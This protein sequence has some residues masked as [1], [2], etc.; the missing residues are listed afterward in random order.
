MSMW[1]G[2][3]L[4]RSRFCGWI[5]SG[6]TY[7][8]AWY[9]GTCNH[10]CL[11][12]LLEG[13]LREPK[14]RYPP[15]KQGL[16]FVR[17]HETFILT[18]FWGRGGKYLCCFQFHLVHP[19]W[20]TLRS[21][22]LSQR[23][24]RWKWKQVINGDGVSCAGMLDWSRPQMMIM[25]PALKLTARPWKLMVGRCNFL[26][27]GAM[28]VSGRVMIMTTDPTRMETVVRYFTSQAWPIAT[29]LQW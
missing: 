8:Y 25:I 28:L 19:A 11:F 21:E 22:R 6:D 27:A 18:C 16:P 9:R 7:N 3:N 29:R 26:F 2:S 13:A 10:M 12:F 1:Y 15:Q 5:G 4:S 17:L 20:R 14:R 23:A 24:C